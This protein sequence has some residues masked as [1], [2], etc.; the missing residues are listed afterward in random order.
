MATSGTV[1]GIVHIVKYSSLC[2]TY[3]L[4]LWFSNIDIFL[5]VHFVIPYIF[6]TYS[7]DNTQLLFS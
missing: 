3:I 4:R 6:P 2:L 5:Y 1:E 7:F